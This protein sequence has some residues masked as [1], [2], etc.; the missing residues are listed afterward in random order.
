MFVEMNEPLPL[1]SEVRVRFSF[2]GSD[3]EIIARGEVNRHHFLNF[4]DQRDK[5]PQ[6][7]VGMGV[8]FSTFEEDGRELLGLG[9][10]RLSIAKTMH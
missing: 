7:M 5:S 3:A 1:G 10:T 8:R 9:V 2:E 4:A 6:S